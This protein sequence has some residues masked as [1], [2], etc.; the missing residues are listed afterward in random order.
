MN[1][2]R[3]AL[4]MLAKSPGFTAVA[5]V[6]LAL[7]IGVNTAVFSIIDTL[8]LR[9]L[10]YPA[11]D[12]LVRVFRVTPDSSRSPNAAADF[13]DYQ[14]QNTVFSQMTAFVW[15][16]FNLADNQELPEAVLTLGVTANFFSVLGMEPELGRCFYPEEDQ[17]GRN[18]VIVLS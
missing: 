4:R 8:W 9:A 10:P 6:T 12:R 7:C 3:F 1:D 13:L 2:F 14:Q 16:G 11:A 5:V 15:M 18:D 17:P